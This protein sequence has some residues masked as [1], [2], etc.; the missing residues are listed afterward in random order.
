MLKPNT[1]Y[2]TIGD[3]W[4]KPCRG[5]IFLCISII[6]DMYVFDGTGYW[7]KILYKN[8]ILEW[9]FNEYFE[10]YVEEIID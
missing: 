1:F 6:P 3:I 10:K 5:D 4:Y 7:I 2:R 8:K 9:S